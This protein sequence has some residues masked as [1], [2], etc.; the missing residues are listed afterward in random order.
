M[1]ASAVAAATLAGHAGLTK[2]PDSAQSKGNKAILVQVS[3]LLILRLFLIGLSIFSM[4]G[5]KRTLFKRFQ[6]WKDSDLK[7][8][9][10][11]LKPGILD[12]LQHLMH[13]STLKQKNRTSRQ[14]NQG[15]TKTPPKKWTG[16]TQDAGSN[17]ILFHIV[18]G[19]EIRHPSVVVSSSSITG[20]QKHPRWLGM[21]F[22]NHPTVGGFFSIAAKVDPFGAVLAGLIHHMDEVAHRPP[23]P[24]VSGW[25]DLKVENPVWSQD[26]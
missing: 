17:R 8:W 24:P 7:N 12:L 10:F 19:S 15:T 20:V 25:R 13:R 6:F 18:D 26:F 2:Q 14:T 5:E 16:K 23:P 4:E 21:G 1:D 22:L 11:F 3:H 9:F